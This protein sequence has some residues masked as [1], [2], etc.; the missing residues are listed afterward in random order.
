MEEKKNLRKVFLKKRNKLSQKEV[1]KNSEMIYWEILN[2]DFYRNGGEIFIYVSMNNE[3]STIKMIKTA[4][5]DG[6]SVAVP[7][8]NSFKKEMF[9]SRIINLEELEVGH[10]NVLEPKEEFIRPV[11]ANKN[12]IILVPGAVFDINKNRIGYGGGYYDRYLRKYKNISKTIGLAYSFQV[13]DKIP[14]NE[15]DIPVD[16]IVTEKYWVN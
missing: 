8:V 3:V 13:I 4:L 10:F 9:F 1:D 14:S 15:Y 16:L 5:I 2:S 12:T 11:E 7:K 6:K